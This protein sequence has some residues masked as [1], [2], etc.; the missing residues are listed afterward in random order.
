MTGKTR[1][2]AGVKLIGFVTGTILMLG[3]VAYL[4]PPCSAMDAMTQS[5]MGQFSGQQGITLGFGSTSTV[6]ATFNSLS[7]GD[8][9][10][11][12]NSQDNNPG[13]IVLIGDGSNTGVLSTTVP[14]GAIMNIDVATTGGSTCS[15]GDFGGIA[16]P[17]NTS[18]FTFT[19]T[20]A[21][22]GLDTPTTINIMGTNNPNGLPGTMDLV[23]YVYPVNIMIDKA[24]MT[25]TCYVWAH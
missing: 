18:Y 23:G 3:F 13:W 14:C 19:L 4:L 24:D 1:K 16:I 21:T 10:G 9:D 25:S 7:W 8:S 11:W 22:I 5:E 15:P 20:K 12:G 2:R 6:I 17:P